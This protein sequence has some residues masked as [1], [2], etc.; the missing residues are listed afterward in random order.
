[1]DIKLTNVFL[2]L[3][4]KNMNRIYLLPDYRLAKTDIKFHIDRPIIRVEIER[5]ITIYYQRTEQGFTIDAFY[6]LNEYLI[7][8]W[9]LIGFYKNQ[10]GCLIITNAN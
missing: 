8:S 3:E 2:A 10:H 4:K 9:L 5:S 7:E 1:M 6:E